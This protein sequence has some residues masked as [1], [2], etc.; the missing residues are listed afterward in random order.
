MFEAWRQQQIVLDETHHAI[1]MLQPAAA[2][3]HARAQ[4]LTVNDL[5]RVTR[6]SERTQRWLRDASIIVVQEPFAGDANT[7]RARTRAEFWRY[8]PGDPGKTP[9]PYSAVIRS[10]GGGHNCSFTYVPVTQRV[11]AFGMMGVGC[12]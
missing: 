9:V 11:I 5:A 6:L 7:A 12:D 4:H 2:T 1:E 3:L 8:Y 10:V